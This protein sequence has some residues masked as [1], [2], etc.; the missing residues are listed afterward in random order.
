MARTLIWVAFLAVA[1]WV[2][3]RM[4]YDGV[5][6]EA[7]LVIDVALAIVG[8]VVHLIGQMLDF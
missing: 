3:V 1:T 5:P 7:T 4:F 8:Y 2:N 6:M